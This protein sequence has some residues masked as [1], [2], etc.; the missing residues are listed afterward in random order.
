M[1]FA[2]P[3]NRALTWAG[4]PT[5][6]PEEGSILRVAAAPFSARVVYPDGTPAGGAMP[7]RLWR[8]GEREFLHT[9]LT[10]DDGI[11]ALPALEEGRYVLVVN[12][13]VMVEM[14]VS[15]EVKPLAGPAQIVIPRGQGAYAGLSAAQQ[16]VML[17]AMT[18]VPPDGPDDEERRGLGLFETV[19][20]SGAA[21]T[22]VAVANAMDI[23]EE[24]RRGIVSP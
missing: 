6:G 2:V 15:R 3:L 7:V 23:F 16:L 21:V 17:A 1:L 9:A 18:A 12:D 19:V 24:T 22:V 20:I 4:Q 11:F 8:V 10:D 14:E 5:S 13:R